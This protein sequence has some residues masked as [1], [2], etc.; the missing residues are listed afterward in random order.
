VR[1]RVYA[2]AAAGTVTSSRAGAVSSARTDVVLWNL[3]ARGVRTRLGLPA[4]LHGRP[5]LLVATLRT[6]AAGRRTGVRTL[7]VSLVPRRSAR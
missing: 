3:Q 4:G 6:R 5:A 1:A 7:V 2:V